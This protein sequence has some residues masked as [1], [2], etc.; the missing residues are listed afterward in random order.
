[1]TYGINGILTPDG[2]VKANLV[3]G[4]A[5]REIAGATAQ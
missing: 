4:A 3:R 2:T 5:G 1:M